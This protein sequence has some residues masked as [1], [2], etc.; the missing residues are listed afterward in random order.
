MVSEGVAMEV[1]KRVKEVVV[2]NEMAT[3]ET[4]CCSTCVAV[5]HPQS[6][7]ASDSDSEEEIESGA[8]TKGKV[9]SRLTM[10]PLL[11]SKFLGFNPK[12]HHYWETLVCF[13]HF[14]T[15]FC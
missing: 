6:F 13:L 4:P 9:A 11:N 7:V 3:F 14:C 2:A 1:D 10:K 15:C 5:T 12:L 8:N